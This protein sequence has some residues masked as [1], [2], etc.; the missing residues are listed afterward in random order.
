MLS[1][2]DTTMLGLTTRAYGPCRGFAKW[3]WRNIAHLKTT[4][5]LAAPREEPCEEFIP[6]ATAL[7]GALA[8]GSVLTDVSHSDRPGND[9]NLRD[10]PSSGPSQRPPAKAIGMRMR[11]EAPPRGGHLS[12]I[13]YGSEGGEPAGPWKLDDDEFI[14]AAEQVNPDVGHLGSNNTFETSKGRFIA[15]KQQPRKQDAISFEAPFRDGLSIQ[16]S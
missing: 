11:K 9:S 12:G 16:W 7:E 1:I 4:A 15:L 10:P 2:T 14:V 3:R 5:D 6:A 13:S 8:D